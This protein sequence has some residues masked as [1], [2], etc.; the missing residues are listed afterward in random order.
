MAVDSK[1][2]IYIAEVG[3]GNEAGHRVQKFRVVGS[4]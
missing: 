1:G 2:N 3:V 4:Q